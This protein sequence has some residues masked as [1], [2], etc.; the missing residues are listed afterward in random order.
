M[1]ERPNISVGDDKFTKL[2]R[3]R[4]NVNQCSEEKDIAKM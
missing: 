3:L 2:Q 1:K 4:L